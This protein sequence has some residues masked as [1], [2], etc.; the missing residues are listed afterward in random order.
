MHHTPERNIAVKKIRKWLI[1]GWGALCIAFG[2]SHFVSIVNLDKHSNPIN[3]ADA[4]TPKEENSTP[5]QMVICNDSAAAVSLMRDELRQIAQADHR[6]L[7]Q[8]LWASRCSRTPVSGDSVAEVVQFVGAGDTEGQRQRRP[9]AFQVRLNDGS[10]GWVT[11]IDL[12]QRQWPTGGNWEAGRGI[13]DLI[14]KAAV[15]VYEANLWFKQNG[16]G[17]PATNYPTLLKLIGSNLTRE[18]V[19]KWGQDAADTIYKKSGLYE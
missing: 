13:I 6:D 19:T 14:D 18:Q 17:D 4:A 16:A 8:N 3:S 1:Y 10:V 9:F 12:P 11:S 7:H 5:M 2:I 15:T